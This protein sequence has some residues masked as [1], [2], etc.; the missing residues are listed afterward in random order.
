VAGNPDTKR[1]RR[2]P[3]PRNLTLS[4]FVERQKVSEALKGFQ[5]DKENDSQW[6]ALSDRIG[7]I[8]FFGCRGKI[9]F[10][11]FSESELSDGDMR[12]RECSAFKMILH[13][14]GMGKMED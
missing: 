13:K 6:Y 4:Y 5:Q 12:Y 7:E 14:L 2:L 8:K 10:N 9:S 3:A 11:S 1:V